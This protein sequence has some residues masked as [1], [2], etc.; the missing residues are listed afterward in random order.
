MIRSLVIGESHTVCIQQA[1]HDEP[2]RAQGI[3]IHRLQSGR[4]SIDVDALS[5]DQ[6]IAA[7]A[8]LPAQTP[9]ILSKLGTYHNVLGLLFFERDFDFQICSLRKAD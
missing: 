6:A 1:A 2:W 8:G 4:R 3:D 5:L 7:I 9:I